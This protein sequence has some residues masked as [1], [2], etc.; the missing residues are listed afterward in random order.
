MVGLVA[1]VGAATAVRD[2]SAF[3]GTAF[4]FNLNDLFELKSAFAKRERTVVLFL[5]LAA[6]EMSCS[7]TMNGL[8]AP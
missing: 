8:R 4:M 6:V 7:G 3:H 2:L 5:Q 1:A